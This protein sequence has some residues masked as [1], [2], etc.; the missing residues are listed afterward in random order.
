MPGFTMELRLRWSG[1]PRTSSKDP[2]AR[3]MLETVDGGAGARRLRDPGGRGQGRGDPLRPR[4]PRPLPRHLP[5]AAVRGHRDRPQPGRAGGGQLER[6]RGRHPLPGDRPAARPA[7]VADKGGTM[8]L[9]LDPCRIQKGTR[10]ERAYGDGLVFERHRHRYEVNNRFRRRLEEAGL[11]LLRDLARRPPGG[12]DRARRRIPGSWPASSTPSSAPARPDRTRCS[13]TSWA[14]PQPSPTTAT[15]RRPPRPRASAPTGS[16]AH[17]NGGRAHPA[18]ARGIPSRW[19]RPRP[20]AQP[21]SRAEEPRSAGRGSR[22]PSR[23]CRSSTPT[24]GPT[25]PAGS[26][27]ARIRTQPRRSSTPPGA[28]A[29]EREGNRAPGGARTAV[30]S[31]APTASADAPT[32]SG[33]H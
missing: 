7:R 30:H 13:G 11:V 4:G 12:D 26:P 31:P 28:G 8:R 18:P 15:A 1:A 21:R 2:A 6:V 14:R 16:P 20:P 5:G 17:R 3:K 29:P 9:G 33:S 24:P 32:A 10:A 27:M 19:R 23:G 25:W 22:L